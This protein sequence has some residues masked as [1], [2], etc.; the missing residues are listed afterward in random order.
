LHLTNKSAFVTTFIDYYGIHETHSFPNWEKRLEY[1]DKNARMDFLEQGMKED[2]ADDVR[3]R[4][5][6]YIQ[7]HE[8]EGLLFNNIGAFERVFSPTEIND[9]DALSNIIA[10]YPNPEL[11]NDT[12]TNAPSKRLMRLISGYNKVVYGNIIAEEIGLKNIREKSPRFDAWLSKLE[13]IGS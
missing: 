1:I 3:F 2:I 4:F 12:P 9:N 5:I 7:L 10:D 8:F 6:P 11:I 13:N